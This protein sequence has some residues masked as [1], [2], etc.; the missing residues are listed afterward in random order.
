M[1]RERKKDSDVPAK[2]NTEIWARCHFPAP[3]LWR[4]RQQKRVLAWRGDSRME[5]GWGWGRERGCL[6]RRAVRWG[7]ADQTAKE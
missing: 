3:S 1:E 2:R 5:R 7:E 4:Q 6:G